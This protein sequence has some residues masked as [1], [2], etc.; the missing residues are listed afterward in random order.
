MSQDI[1]PARNKIPRQLFG[2]RNR[3]K[4]SASFAPRTQ[5]AFVNGLRKDEKMR[6]HSA[7]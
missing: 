7:A 2:N 6:T 4:A 3:R 1:L 5:L